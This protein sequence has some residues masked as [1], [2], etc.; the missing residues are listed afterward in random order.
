MNFVTPWSNN[1]LLQT[2]RLHDR[3]ARHD[4]PSN[5]NTTCTI[6][7]ILQLT[8][9]RSPRRHHSALEYY[10]RVSS[11]TNH[12]QLLLPTPSLAIIIH[13]LQR[14]TNHKQPLLLST[15]NSNFSSSI[16]KHKQTQ[17]LLSLSMMLRM[18]WCL[19]LEEEDVVGDWMARFLHD[20][21]LLLSC[22]L[23][24]LHSSRRSLFEIFDVPTIIDAMALLL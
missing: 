5:I 22:Q 13:N 6:H 1:T 15:S 9:L 2:T 24:G 3:L 16:H 20:N 19:W 10:N 21:Q 23:S 11:S 7:I 18:E 14:N 4:V 8:S 12:K 17:Y